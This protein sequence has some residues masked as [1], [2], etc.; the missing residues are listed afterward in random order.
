MVKFQATQK[1]IH[2]DL[3]NLERYLSFKGQ[4]AIQK[5]SKRRRG[6]SGQIWTHAKVWRV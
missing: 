6:K 5:G 2:E 1:D 4:A 3:P